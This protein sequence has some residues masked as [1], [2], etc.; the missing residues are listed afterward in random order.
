MDGWMDGWMDE[1]MDG[2]SNVNM[3]VCMQM[4]VRM[5][6]GMD[7]RTYDCMYGWT[8]AWFH[9]CLY[10]CGLLCWAWDPTSDFVAFLRSPWRIAGLHIRTWTPK[11]LLMLNP[12]E[13][14][15]STLTRSWVAV[16]Q[17][18]EVWLGNSQ[19]RE[20]N[21]YP[22]TQP[23]LL[24]PTQKPA[25]LRLWTRKHQSHKTLNPKPLKP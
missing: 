17:S 2:C 22:K 23:Q 20:P 12:C 15:P 14:G 5:D 21:T 3:Y 16:P 24:K 8:N 11:H 9:V 19:F 18:S 7:V 1:W 13:D 6:R 10:V 25:S 4:D